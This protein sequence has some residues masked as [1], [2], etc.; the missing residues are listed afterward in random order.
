[1]NEEQHCPACGAPVSPNPRYPDHLCRD[2]AGKVTT[3]DG[4]ALAFFNLGMSG[5]YGAKIAASGEDYPSHMCYLDGREYWA[6]EARFGGIVIR[7]V[8][9]GER[10]ED[11]VRA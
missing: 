10:P 8:A 11:G 1:M 3:R 7:P 6:D 9:G 4:R 2:C 5:G